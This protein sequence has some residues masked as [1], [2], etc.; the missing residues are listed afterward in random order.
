MACSI[1]ENEP[2]K[3]LADDLKIPHQCHSTRPRCI[4]G[5]ERREGNNILG[6]P[7]R[8]NRI[9]PGAL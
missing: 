2:L 6:I 5:F 7:G 4:Q 3:K 1:A 8:G 9:L